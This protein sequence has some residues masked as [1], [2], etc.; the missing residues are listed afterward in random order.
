[1]LTFLPNSACMYLQNQ[2]MKMTKSH[3]CN[4]TKELR[5]ISDLLIFQENKVLADI[6]LGKTLNLRHI[7]CI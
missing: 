3:L 4:N 2:R 1:M 6:E 7:T 5:P